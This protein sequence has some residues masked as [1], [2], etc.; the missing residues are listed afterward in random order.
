MKRSKISLLVL[1]ASGLMMLLAFQN[2]SKVGFNP[3]SSSAAFKSGQGSD[4]RTPGDDGA[5]DGSRPGDDGAIGGD[6][7]GDDGDMTGPNGPGDDDVAGRDDDEDEDSDIE[8]DEDWLYI[9][10]GRGHVPMS[11]VA[12]CPA[13][14]KDEGNQKCPMFC[15]QGKDYV[16]HKSLARNY[17]VKK[18]DE[19]PNY[20]GGAVPGTCANPD[21]KIKD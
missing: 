16:M 6:R 8:D 18:F 2:C 15:Y 7:P 3:D 13:G 9:P 10:G 1:I 19:V 4:G 20:G 14:S 12:I 17:F 11:S 21:L 5:I